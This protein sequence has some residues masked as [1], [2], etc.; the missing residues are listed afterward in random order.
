MPPPWAASAASCQ[1]AADDPA[2]AGSLVP[3]RSRNALVEGLLSHHGIER[4]I[5]FPVTIRYH[6]GSLNSEG[7]LGFNLSDDNIPIPRCLWMV[8][9]D[10]VRVRFRVM[11]VSPVDGAATSSPGATDGRER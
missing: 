8:L 2:P 4:E 6:D 1:G 7:E 11:E 10:D 9:E 5:R 3:G